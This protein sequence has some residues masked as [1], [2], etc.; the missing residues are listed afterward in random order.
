MIARLGKVLTRVSTR[1][2]PDPFV[3]ALLLTLAVLGLG[4]WRLAAGA[5]PAG[6]P[7][8][9]GIAG[10]L[11]VGWLEGF[12]SKPLLAF[13]LQMCLVLVTGHALATSPPVQAAVGRLARWNLGAAGSAFLVGFVACLAAVVHWGLGAIV[14][15]FLAREIGRHAREHGR[16]LHY[17]LLGGAAYAGLAVWHGGLS[18]SAPLKVAEAGHFAESIAGVLPVEETLFSPLNLVVTGT[19][20]VLIPLVFALMTPPEEERVGPDATQLAPPEERARV[21]PDSVPGWLQETP[22][23]GAVL[24]VAGLGVLF[25]AWLAGKVQLDL[26][27][28]NLLFLFL[29][30]TLQGSLRAYVEAVAEGARGAGAIIVQFPF[31]FGVLGVMKA[32]GMIGW[33][34]E[35]LVSVASESSFPVLAFLSAGV[36][37]LFVPSGGGQWAVQGEILLGTG[38]D[39]GVDP[40][41]TVMAFSYGDAWTNMLQ[42][43]WALPLLGIMGL[44]A[45]DI[46]GYTGVVFLLVGVLVPL[47]LVTLP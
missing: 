36:V 7:L 38:A 12:S 15:A 31:Y 30:V 16:A 2:V 9:Q 42:P 18:G 43:F 13:A 32:S 3:L 8:A 4:A 14:G 37:N 6:E 11:F 25:A 17:P 41:V 1:V 33:I 34:S 40:G 10:T 44:K 21:A 46:I 27:L 19:L 29:G 23:V 20:C 47:L 35:G 5:P 24:G 45:R 22:A 28:V 39:L 26:D